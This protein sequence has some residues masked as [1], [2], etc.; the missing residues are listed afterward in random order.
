MIRTFTSLVIIAAAGVAGF[1]SR[2]DGAANRNFTVH[3]WGTFTSL[4]GSNGVQLVGLTHDDEPLPKFVYHYNK[5]EKGFEGVM[6]KMETPVIYFYSKEERDVFVSVG[7]PKGVLTQWYPQV[8]SI[9]PAVGDRE[10][11]LKNGKLGWGLVHLFAPEKGT[12]LLEKTNDKEIWNF[13]R[14]VDANILRVCG[15]GKDKKNDYNEAE[16]FLFYRGLGNFELPLAASMNDDHTIQVINKSKDPLEGAV[17]IKVEKG[18]IFMNDAGA[19][20]GGAKLQMT[21]DLK[22]ASVEGAMDAVAKRITAAGLFDKE[23]RAMVKTWR[24]SYFETEG[25][26]ILYIVPRALTD[27]ILPLTLDP[28]PEKLTRVLV[29]RFDILTPSAEKRAEEQIKK[30]KT[31]AEAGAAL[32]R[33]AEPVIEHIR[34]TTKDDNSR[35]AAHALLQMYQKEREN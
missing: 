1:F 34:D 21:A 2:D 13:A 29:G 17:Y 31:P 32:G 5:Q 18:N 22:P 10:P 28:M 19:I 20:P 8:R 27:E 7:F 14:E 35:R 3:E 15:S 4:A 33:F 11:E 23:A 9:A 12:E 26:R 6:V 30:V 16:R 25:L 24:K